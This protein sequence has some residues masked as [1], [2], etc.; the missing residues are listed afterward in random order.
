MRPQAPEWAA[1][2][3]GLPFEEKGRCRAG[4][5]CWGLVRLVLAEQFALQVPSYADLYHSTSDMKRLSLAFT[6]NCTESAD[7]LSVEAG[8]ECAGD[9]V[10]LRMRGR[11]VTRSLIRTD[12][13]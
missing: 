6:E 12:D 11:P 5:D 4:V 8:S 3:V 7:W 13:A 9:A 1:G 10:L 2:Y